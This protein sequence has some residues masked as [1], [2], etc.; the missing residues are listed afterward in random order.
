MQGRLEA[1]GQHFK[2]HLQNKVTEPQGK[3]RPNS[4]WMQALYTTEFVQQ[5]LC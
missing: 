1:E 4:H 5:R 3:N 2:T